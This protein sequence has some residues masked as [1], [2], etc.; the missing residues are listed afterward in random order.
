MK[1]AEE[2]L[3][4]ANATEQL[5]QYSAHVVNLNSNT[6]KTLLEMVGYVQILAQ[7]NIKLKEA[8]TK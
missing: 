1:T 2:M 4:Q 3:K 7:E 8:H 5:L 6:M